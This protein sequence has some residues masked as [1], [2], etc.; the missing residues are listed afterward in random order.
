MSVMTASDAK[1][2]FGEVLLKAQKSP[3]R[4]SKNGKPVAVVVSAND[5]ANLEL[6]QR[7]KLKEEIAKGLSDLQ[8]GRVKQGDEVLA[9]LYEKLT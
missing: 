2:E 3:V 6:L 1:R 8:A 9:R 5:Y 4:I 7:L